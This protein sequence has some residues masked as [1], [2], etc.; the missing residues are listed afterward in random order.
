V[1]RHGVGHAPRCRHFVHRPTLCNTARLDYRICSIINFGFGKVG[2]ATLTG[3]FPTRKCNVQVVVVQA[4]RRTPLGLQSAMPCA[5]P[6]HSPEEPQS[7]ARQQLSGSAN[8]LPIGI[9]WMYADRIKLWHLKLTTASKERRLVDAV[10]SYWVIVGFPQSA[11]GTVQGPR[12]P[13][14][15]KSTGERN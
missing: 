5:P 10:T 7:C 9:N 15:T 14:K 1:L 13:Q 2:Y 8:V 11:T 6:D 3:I 4:N 12:D